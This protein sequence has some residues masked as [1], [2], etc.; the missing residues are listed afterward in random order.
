MNAPQPTRK[1]HS[2]HAAPQRGAAMIEVLVS[3]LIVAFGIMGMF[4][5][6]TQASVSQ[7]ESY[8]RAQALVLVKDMAQRMEA[9][10][11]QIAAYVDNDIGTAAATDC[12][13]ETTTAARD[14]CE[15]GA[16]LQGA[17]EVLNGSKVGA[18]IGARG[19]ISQPD[20]VA[21]PNVYM[22][23]VVWQGLRETGAPNVACGK[24]AYGSEATRRAATVVLQISV[25]S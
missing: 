8:Q 1:K 24:D 22:V 21:A 20:P 10:R 23:A 17:A 14:K 16:L 12:T 11:A 18:M 9:N 15:W 13:L 7:M 25:L 2:R 19:C 5:M 6:Q 4:G 3:M